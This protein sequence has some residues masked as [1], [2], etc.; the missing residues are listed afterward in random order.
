VPALANVTD[1]KDALMAETAIARN[2]AIFGSPTFAVGREP[3]LGR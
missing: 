3:F 2:L 1:T